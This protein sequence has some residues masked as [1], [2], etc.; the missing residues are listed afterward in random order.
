MGHFTQDTLSLG[1]R[2]FPDPSIK[3][4]NGSLALYLWASLVAQTVKRL[5]AMWEIQVRPLGR[6][7]P[8]EKDMA[9]TPVFLPGKFHRQRNLVGYVVHGVA[10]SWTRLSDF[11]FTS[12]ITLKTVLAPKPESKV[13][14]SDDALYTEPRISKCLVSER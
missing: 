7:D 8:L 6:E 10:K 11:P 5:P 9:T 13:K 3:Q 2:R 12:S 4:G 1:S 14:T